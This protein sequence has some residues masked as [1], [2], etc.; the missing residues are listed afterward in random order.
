M[1]NGFFGRSDN[2]LARSYVWNIVCTGHGMS[3]SIIKV[4]LA[5]LDLVLE[6]TVS[7]RFL[8]FTALK[9]LGVLALTWLTLKIVSIIV[10]V[11]IILLPR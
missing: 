6:T 9:E 11:A 7:L 4:L 10:V 1:K 2:P 8:I 5:D 3:V